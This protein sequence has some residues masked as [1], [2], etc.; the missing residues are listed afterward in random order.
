MVDRASHRAFDHLFDARAKA[1]P[2]HR[3]RVAALRDL[4]ADAWSEAGDDRV[5]DDGDLDAAVGIH[6]AHVARAED[7]IRVTRRKG[8]VRLIAAG[9]F[10]SITCSYDERRCGYD[11]DPQ[12]AEPHDLPPVV[13]D[14]LELEI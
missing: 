8:S 5:A 12:S 7:A 6:H 1:A 14:V 13:L 4:G 11:S 10:G 3:A 9:V 2:R